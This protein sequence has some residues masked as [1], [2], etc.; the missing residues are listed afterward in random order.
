LFW[1]RQKFYLN[2]QLHAVKILKHLSMS[3][4]LRRN[5]HSVSRL[6]YSFRPHGSNSPWRVS[7]D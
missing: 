6:R 4:D 2:G 5:N 3:N 1:R 7:Y